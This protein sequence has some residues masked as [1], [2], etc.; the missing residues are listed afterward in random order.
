MCIKMQINFTKAFYFNEERN[1]PNELEKNGK[2][3]L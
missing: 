1:V 3:L 2:E